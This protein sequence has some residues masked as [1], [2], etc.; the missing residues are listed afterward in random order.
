ME[1]TNATPPTDVESEFKE[2]MTAPDAP[3]LVARITEL[4]DRNATLEG[5]AASAAEREVQLTTERDAALAK[6]AAADKA[7]RAAKLTLAG[8]PAQPRKLTAP[9]PD[10]G[11]TTTD[12]QKRLR[13]LITDATSVEI[14]FSDGVKEIAGLLP[15][16][17]EGEAWRDHGLGLMLTAPVDLRAPIDTSVSVAGYAL[18][19]DGK[20]VAA[21]QR[22][23]KVN[24]AGGTTVSLVDDIYF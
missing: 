7:A 6:V 11:E 18:L 15:I 14:A 3:H 10:E 19:I 1:D 8:K 12:R 23:D 16:K 4:E 17:V 13:A 2:A 22:G 24:I 21:T 20:V 9:K 5:E